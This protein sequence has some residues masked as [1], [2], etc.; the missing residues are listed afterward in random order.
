[1]K[2]GEFLKNPGSYF[3]VKFDFRNISQ[4]RFL[5]E[6]VDKLKKEE[7]AR[8]EAR[9]PNEDKRQVLLADNKVKQEEIL[10]LKQEKSDRKTKQ[11]MLEKRWE[12]MRWITTYIDEN[13]ESWE[14]EKKE[15]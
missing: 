15:R 10:R 7:T 14:N 6:T 4:Y 2:Q 13:S 12:M 8:N 3:H 1:M 11:K 9:K 5:E